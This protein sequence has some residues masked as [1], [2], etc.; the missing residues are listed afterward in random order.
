MVL[1]SR[2]ETSCAVVVNET[3]I[4]CPDRSSNYSQ[5]LSSS[6]SSSASSSSSTEMSSCVS[7]RVPCA[8]AC[9]V[10]IISFLVAFNVRLPQLPYPLVGSLLPY[11]EDVGG[12]AWWPFSIHILLAAW[13]FHFIRRL[14][15]ILFVH[16]YLR[17]TDNVI[18]YLAPFYYLLFG[19]WIGFAM[20]FHWSW[21]VYSAP[22]LPIIVPALIVFIVGEIGNSVCHAI[23]RAHRR[24]KI[25]AE[26]EDGEDQKPLNNQQL[27]LSLPDECCFRFVSCPHY[28]FEIVSWIGFAAATCT[29]A[30]LVFLVCNTIIVVVL[31]KRRHASYMRDAAQRTD[32][33]TVSELFTVRHALI[34][35]IL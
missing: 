22:V 7:R 29:L 35:K 1:Q 34:P 5:Q 33:V 20:N 26:S 10:A 9:I 24:Y 31:A 3:T 12:N 14:V 17:T 32:K 23:L 11:N 28:L 18:C 30:S 6:S 19:L 13:A 27:V 2:D 21:R 25:D 16:E 15:E 4:F 8:I